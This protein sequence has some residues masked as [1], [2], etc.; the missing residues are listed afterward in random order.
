MDELWKEKYFL[1]PE[2]LCERAMARFWDRFA[3]EKPWGTL[4]AVQAV[5]LDAELDAEDVLEEFELQACGREVVRQKRST[6]TKVCQCFSSSN[7]VVYRSE[8]SHK[9]EEI[10]K[11][12]DQIAG[13]RSKFILSESTAEDGHVIPKEREI[14]PF[15]GAPYVIGREDDKEGYKHFNATNQRRGSLCHSNSWNWVKALLL[16][17][18][19]MI[20]NVNDFF[21][22][23]IWIYVSDEFDVTRLMKEI[24]KF[25]TNDCSKLERGE[26]RKRL[27]EILTDKKFLFVM[28]D[29]WNEKP[30]KWMDLR[31]LLLN[32]V[33]GSKIIVSTRSNRVVEI[34]S[35]SH[36]HFLQ[37]LSTKESLLLF[38][39]YVFKDGKG[40]DFPRLTEIGKEIVRKCKGVPL[41]MRSLGSLF[42][43]N[44]NECEWL[45]IR[46]ND[47]WQVDQDNE[48]NLPVL[49]LSY[50]HLPPLLK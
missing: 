17:W 31:K 25:A 34:M 10:R 2:D 42:Y 40:K 36:S 43:A 8:I 19:T 28:D 14:D 49:K 22:L 23:K 30:Q 33:N 13:D 48:D 44:T 3:D 7:P 41:A 15:L 20:K 16:K 27:Q 32:G 46:E 1:V 38:K 37:G 4:S 12:L 50:D 24:I 21:L 18:F 39:K 47:I 5:L 9:I 29:V 35:T 6:L 11:R 45:K 26:I